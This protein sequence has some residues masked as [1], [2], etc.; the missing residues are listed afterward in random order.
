MKAF[1]KTKPICE[2]A[3]FGQD[4][5]ASPDVLETQI[6]VNPVIPSNTDELKKQSQF[7]QKS[8]MVENYDCDEYLQGL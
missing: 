4:L 1:E 5:R 3:E 8:G 2:R 7:G 6:R